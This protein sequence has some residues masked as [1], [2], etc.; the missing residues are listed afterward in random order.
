MRAMPLDG[1]YLLHMSK[2]VCKGRPARHYLGYAHDIRA[3]VFLHRI[4]KGAHI[5][6]AARSR[7]AHLK[8]A[9]VWYGMGRN[10]ERKLK[11]QRNLPRL[12]PICNPGYAG[13][14]TEMREMPEDS[15]IA[16]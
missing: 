14:Y 4:G 6:Q 1:V 5:T 3:R 16:F 2:R 12:C 13:C 11:N 15:E 7:G 10:F 8:L 9:R